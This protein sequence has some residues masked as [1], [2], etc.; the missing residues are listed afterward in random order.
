VEPGILVSVGREGDWNG[1]GLG[2]F[3]LVLG[4]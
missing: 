3:C 2:L 1:K 4:W